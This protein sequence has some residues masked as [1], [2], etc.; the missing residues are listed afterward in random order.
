MPWQIVE[1]SAFSRIE[2]AHKHTFVLRGRLFSKNSSLFHRECLCAR[3]FIILY[4]TLRYVTGSKI[5]VAR[6]N[7]LRSQRTRT[8][9]IVTKKRRTQ[10]SKVLM[11]QLSYASTSVYFYVRVSNVNS[12]LNVICNILRTF[13]CPDTMI[14]ARNIFKVESW[15]KVCHKKLTSDCRIYSFQSLARTI[16]GEEK[17]RLPI[18]LSRFLLRSE[19][20]VSDLV[21]TLL[22]YS[23][24]INKAQA[25]SNEICL[26]RN[27]RRENRKRCRAERDVKGNI[28]ESWNPRPKSFR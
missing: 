22:L 1:F 3:I 9:K 19:K 16:A 12:V 23:F 24:I 14:H 7:K 13:L 27:V 18:Q 28:Q 17:F 25:A 15:K 2:F 21:F 6:K 5:K 8:R 10:L 20:I 26:T 4:I 11:L